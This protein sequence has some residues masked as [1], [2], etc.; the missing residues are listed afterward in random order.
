MKIKVF[1][2]LFS[3][4]ICCFFN[5]CSDDE[6]GGYS[7]RE[8]E[9][10]EIVLKVYSNTKGVPVSVQQGLTIKDYW[11]SK[12]VTQMYGAQ[13]QA[14]CVDLTVLLTGE[15][16][17]DGKLKAKGEANGVLKVNAQIK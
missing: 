14:Y 3:I 10:H 4:L 17:V 2:V 8:K 1:L 9:R 11:E 12:Y 5:S 13:I 16:Y 15:I 7:K 6:D